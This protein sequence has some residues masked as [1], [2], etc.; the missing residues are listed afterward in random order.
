MVEV[1]MKA[2]VPHPFGSGGRFSGIVHKA[3]IITCHDVSVIF[4]GSMRM[5]QENHRQK[6]QVQQVRNASDGK[7]RLP[8]AGTQGMNPF[9]Q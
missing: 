3:V 8:E 1:S 6:E 7:R 2:I 9:Y 4:H 5:C